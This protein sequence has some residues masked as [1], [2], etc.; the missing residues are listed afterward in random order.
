MLLAYETHTRLS[1]ASGHQAAEASA[2]ASEALIVPTEDV[3]A[4]LDSVPRD[5]SHPPVLADAGSAAIVSVQLESLQDPEPGSHEPALLAAPDLVAQIVVRGVG[6][7]CPNI[8]FMIEQSK[9]VGI[10]SIA[11]HE[12]GAAPQRQ[13]DGT[14]KS[15]L[16]SRR[17]ALAQRRV[18]EQ[19]VYLFDASGLVVYDQWYQFLHFRFVAPTRM[20]GLVR[21]PHRGPEQA[22]RASRTH[23]DT[24]A[25][26]MSQ[27]SFRRRWAREA[28]DLLELVL[29]PGAAAALPWPLGYRVL[30]RLARWPALFREVLRTGSARCPGP[31]A[32]GRRRR[33]VA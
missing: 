6:D 22:T 15:V 3:A 5:V 31:W 24:G 27:F 32:G 20:P 29:L 23:T 8:G 7:E 33:L 13:P 14:W 2:Q 21:L 16:T 17:P 11:S 9:G 1:A 28:Q 12:E 10:T 18:R 4:T 30:R 25:A 26:A 19:S